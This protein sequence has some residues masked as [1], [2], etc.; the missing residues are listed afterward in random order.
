MNDQLTLDFTKPLTH[1]ENNRESQLHFE[2]NVE[3]FSKQCKIVYI[4]MKSGERLTTAKALVKYG[5]GDLRRRV[6]DLIDNWGVPVQSD[7]HHDP[8]GN[9]TRYKEYFLKLD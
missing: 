8:E 2:S 6:K 1:K 5:V 7:Y 9:K 4:A 3:H